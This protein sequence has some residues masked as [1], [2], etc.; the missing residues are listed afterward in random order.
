MPTLAFKSFSPAEGGLSLPDTSMPWLADALDSARAAGEIARNITLRDGEPLQGV[1]VFTAKLIR[2]KSGRRCLIEYDVGITARGKTCRQT[3]I[4]KSRSRG[5]DRRTF[6]LA[7]ELYRSGFDDCSPDGISIPEPVGVVPRF[8]MWLSRKV[9][10]V[11]GA[12]VISG[13][14]G[15]WVATR[16][17]AVASKIHRVMLPTVVHHT[18]ER[19]LEILGA[20]LEDVQA[21]HPQ[22]ASRL[23]ALMCR[24][25]EI[26]T[27]MG[28][29]PVTGIHR[30]FYPDQLLFGPQR[31]HVVD[32]D[33]YSRG[34]P[35]LDIG[36]VLAH[37][38]EQALRTAGRSTAL[39]EMRQA[40]LA[41]Y[42]E[43]A[44]ASHL[45]AIRAYELFS[46]CRH[47]AIS[48][49]LP[50]RSHMTAEILGLCEEYAAALQRG[51]QS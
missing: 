40:L 50:A 12:E 14:R 2:H 5:L 11:S 35:A 27:A 26:G 47:V 39:D 36:N 29:R 48:E 13:P 49:A 22:W 43:I 6:E 18:V 16:I 46:L 15:S 21:R 25:E 32:F 23:T 45:Q 19:E 7:R 9:D 8:E 3:L 42:V 37:L 33:L 30:D 51:D 17:A 41:Q 24:C 28:G 34:D 20:R 1:E 31:V 10:G 4:G 44:G 38:T